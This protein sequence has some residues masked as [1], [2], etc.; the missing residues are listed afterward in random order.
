MSSVVALQNHETACISA[1]DATE[2]NT[3]LKWKT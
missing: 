2:I 3:C 1:L